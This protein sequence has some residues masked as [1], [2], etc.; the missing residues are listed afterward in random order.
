[1]ADASLRGV[2]PAVLTPFTEDE[3]VDC[4]A[5]AAICRRTIDAGVSALFINGSTGSG[6]L[7]T[8]EEAAANVRAAVDAAEGRVPVLA[9][10]GSNATSTAI[11]LARDAADAGA[12]VAVSQT[13][14]YFPLS[15]CEL[16]GYFADLIV[17]SPIPVALYNIPQLT[18]NVLST[19]MIAE[20]AGDRRC[21]GMKDSSGDMEAMLRTIALKAGAPAFLVWQGAEPLAASSMLAGADGI[22]SGTANVAPAMV[23]AVYEAARSGDIE[24]ARARQESLSR[25]RRFYSAGTPRRVMGVCLEMLGVCAAHQ[26]R[27]YHEPTDEGRAL[28]RSC[29]A[30]AGLLPP[31]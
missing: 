31:S 18:N 5:L 27:P 17:A 14:F 1:M 7:L 3:R 16:M 29:L 20:L 8:R 12:A 19:D 11:D 28:I 10:V 21:V 25:L 9:G 2:I 23:L 4:G 13:P 30:E 6:P 24:P 26:R 22:V 15:R